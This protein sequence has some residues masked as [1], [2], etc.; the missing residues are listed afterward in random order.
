AGCPGRAQRIAE[1]EIDGHLAADR[2]FEIPQ[3]ERSDPGVRDVGY[4][5]GVD[6]MKE[7]GPRADA[8]LRSRESKPVVEIQR[9][10]VTPGGGDVGEASEQRPGVPGERTR[11]R[12]RAATHRKRRTY[13]VVA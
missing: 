6:R 2:A 3:V 11:G 10:R 13:E 9:R 7:R 5:G 12:C 1:D 4:D 8:A